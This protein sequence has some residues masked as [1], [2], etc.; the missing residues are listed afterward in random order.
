[1]ILFVILSMFVAKLL[2]VLLAFYDFL[3]TRTD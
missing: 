1:M 3:G 2:S